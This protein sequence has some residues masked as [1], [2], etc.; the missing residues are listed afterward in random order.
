MVSMHM[1]FPLSPI[2]CGG[3]GAMVPMDGVGD[4]LTMVSVGT[5]GTVRVG[6][7][8]GAAGIVAGVDGGDITI[9]IPDTILVAAI[10][11]EVAAIGDVIL[12][13]HVALRE[14]AVIET[15]PLCAE[16]D[17]R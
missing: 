7:L 15:L 13:L 4:I 2:V 8:A 17:L 3:T 12:I 6:A 10:G 5:A 9:I 14:Q 1:L 11:G 16:V